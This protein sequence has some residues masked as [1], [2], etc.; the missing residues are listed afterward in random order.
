MRIGVIF[1]QIEIGEDPVA[2][3]DWAQAAEGAGFD[4]ILVYDHVLGAHPDRFEGRF[5]PPYNHETPFHEPF[6]LF[7][8]MAALTERIEL[9]TGVLVLPQRQTALVAKQA[10]QADVL[11]GGRVRLGVGIGWNFV[12]YEAL[13]ENFR[14][15][16]RRVEEQVQLMRR[17]WT[18]A[19]VDFDG[20][21]HKVSQS[22]INPLPVQ[23]PIPV[24][25]GGGAEAVLKRIARMADGWFP[26]FRPGPQGA[27]TIE[28]L[29]GYVRDA[30][31]REE[32]VGI[33]GR[34]SM[35]NTPEEQWGEALEGWRGLRASHVSLNTMGVG[36]QSPG[37]HIDAMRRF[38]E[39]ARPAAAQGRQ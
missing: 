27:E 21:Y 16:G 9:T 22:G 23:R 2:I 31:R 19:L 13:G 37:G 28:R 32:D 39:L 30:G 5:R 8:Y 20:R 29:R 11:S 7:G 17:L 33:E 10:A 12:E 26:Q 14:N 36:L 6:V 34:I 35:F 18:E 15:R 38:I 4:H 24:W 3:R 25:M 1:P